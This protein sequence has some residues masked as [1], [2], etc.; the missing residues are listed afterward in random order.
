M[1]PPVNRRLG[2]EAVP[3]SNKGI[4]T[5]EAYNFSLYVRKF[6]QSGNYYKICHACSFK[7]GQ[8]VNQLQVWW[9]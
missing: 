8:K 4:G 7:T 3:K 9:S 2:F 5:V 6:I 1:E